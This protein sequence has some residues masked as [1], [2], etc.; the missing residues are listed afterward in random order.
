MKFCSSEHK[1]LARRIAANGGALPDQLRWCKYCGEPL[2]SHR[3]SDASYCDAV[4]RARAHRAAER[5]DSR[6]QDLER[7]SSGRGTVH[8]RNG[9]PLAGRL[10]AVDVWDRCVG[11]GTGLFSPD[12]ESG[13]AVHEHPGPGTE[14]VPP[15]ASAA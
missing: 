15:D 3:R 14:E 10:P 4:C 5:G 11:R 12:Q 9:K 6:G 2:A 7:V 8:S 1:W 13:P